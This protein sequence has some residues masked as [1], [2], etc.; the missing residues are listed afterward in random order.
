MK[1]HLGCGTVYLKGYINVDADP[2][3]LAQNAPSE[4]LESN[5]TT[6]D[7]YYKHEFGSKKSGL[8]IADLQCFI[9]NLPF[10]NDS[11]DEIIMLHVLEH[12]PTYKVDGILTEFRRVLR[13]GGRLYL[14]VPDIKGT[15]QQLAEATTPEEEDWCIRLIH[16]TQR[17][18]F[19]HH[20]CGYTERTLKNL[21]SGKG[22]G[23]FK[24][25][26]N[27]NFY[28]AIHLEAKKI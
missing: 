23:D 15:A 2:H 7:K 16:G 28:P 27:I 6:L 4:A 1:V 9:E 8:C 10:R 22:F 25:L 20:Y 3:F 21:L 18:E 17:N 26:P 5:T 11:V 13:I 12:L 24:T 19:S 14:G